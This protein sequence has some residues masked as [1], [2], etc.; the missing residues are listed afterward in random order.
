VRAINAEDT[1]E[2]SVV[3]SFD[4]R[5]YVTLTSPADFTVNA[6]ATGVNLNWNSHHGVDFY[7]LQW[8]TTNQFNSG[9]LQTMTETYISSSSGNGDTQ[10]NTGTLL[11]NQTYFWRV[12][13][14]NAVDT[15][16]WSSRVF[17]TG[18][19]ILEPQ[20]PVLVSP[21]NSSTIA[22][23][24][25]N[26]I[27]NSSINATEYEVQY[28]EQI[29]FAANI[30]AITTATNENI[31]GHTNLSTYYWRVRSIDT[32]FYS[33]WSTIWSFDVDSVICTP[34]TSSISVSSCDSYTTPSGITLSNS[35]IYHDV[36][37]NSAGCD[38]TITINLTINNST[39]GIDTQESCS[40]YTWIDGITYTSSNNTATH[41]LPT[42]NGCDSTIKLNLTINNSPPTEDNQTACD[43]YTWIDGLTYSSSNNTA[44]HTLT[45]IAGCDSVITL[46]LIIESIDLSVTASSNTFSANQTG[47]QYQWINCSD[48]S[49]IDGATNQ[50]YTPSS[51]GS[52]AVIISSS[53]CTDTSECVTSNVGIDNHD[54]SQSIRMYPNPTKSVFSLEID[55]NYSEMKIQITNSLEQLISETNHKNSSV[56]NSIIDGKAGL[57]FVHVIVDNQTVVIR[58]VKN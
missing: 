23:T 53:S 27:W 34:T 32:G 28:S 46:D 31:V 4:L 18:T 2:W 38:S 39:T 30:S 52:Y 19:I 11:A 5:D 14:I 16:A 17:S 42:S 22:I 20:I 47:A 9:A 12:R 15:S 50:S 21:S 3:R 8:D 1:S 54:L 45:N 58:M 6:S 7:T 57:Y 49:I 10:H 13:A 26:L 41:T 44:T 33:D 35:I 56:V 24:A 37:P 25:T 29:N 48:S 55:G 40:S 36:V 43:A 51:N